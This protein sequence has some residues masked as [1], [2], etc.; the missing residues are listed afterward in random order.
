MS[1][2]GQTGFGLLEAIVALTLLAAAALPTALGLGAA[3]S[4]TR[5]IEAALLELEMRSN[6]LA[7][8]GAINPMLNPEGALDLGPYR[9]VWT[10]DALDEPRPVVGPLG[11]G[12]V[13][14][15]QAF[16]MRG[17]IEDQTGARASVTVRR[18]GYAAAR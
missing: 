17:R 16:D 9:L 7:T 3:L 1:A 6:A 13:W 10:S 2:R 11:E 12:G 14:V 15:A 4:A 18:V 5:R 8:L